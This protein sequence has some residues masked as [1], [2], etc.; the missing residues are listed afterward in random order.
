MSMS[1]PAENARPDPVSTIARTSSP[2]P[3]SCMISR[4]SRNQVRSM[5]LSFS[6][7]SIVNSRTF[8]FWLRVK[9]SSSSVMSSPGPTCR[10]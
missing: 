1:P 5:A 9:R 4:S 2:T 3:A 6:G 8:P 10:R 7:R